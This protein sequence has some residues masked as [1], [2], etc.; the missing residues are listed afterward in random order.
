MD[1]CGQCRSRS[2][3]TEL[4]SDFGSILSDK[5]ISSPNKHT[6]TQKW[7]KMKY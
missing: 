6:N 1:L 7:A 3:C 5:E 4:Q 2:G